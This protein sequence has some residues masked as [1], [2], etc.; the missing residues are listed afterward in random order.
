MLDKIFK[1]FLVIGSGTIISML[2]GLFTTPLITR[3]VSPY[4]YGQFSIFLMYGQIGILILILGLDQSIVRFFYESEGVKYKQWLLKEC[5][6]WPLFIALITSVVF[7]GLMITDILKFEFNFLFAILL[8]LYIFLLI[9]F[10]FAQLIVRLEYNS[11]LFSLLNIIQKFV[12]III[13]VPAI[14]FCNLDY[15]LVLVLAT[16]TALIICTIIAIYKYKDIWNFFECSWENFNVSEEHL[17]RY[18]YPYI[19]SF[20]IIA[21]FNSSDKLILNYY[22]SYSEVGIY[23]S[24]LSL[25]SIINLIQSTFNTLWAPLAV[26]HFTDFPDDREFYIRANKII[27]VVMFTIGIFLILCKDIFVLLLGEK[28]REASYLLPC[29]IFNPIM[30]TISETTVMGLVF[31]QKSKAHILVALGAAATNIVLCFVLIPYLG[32]KGAAIANALAYIVFFSIRT[33]LSNKYFKV[34]YD[35]KAFYITTLVV[36]FYSL[37]NCFNFVNTIDY[38]FSIICL[39]AIYYF[40]NDVFLLIKESLR[41][42]FRKNQLKN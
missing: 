16:I 7:I 38:L 32:I 24:A 19:I 27:T 40:Y 6:K 17:L 28:Y 11:K 35:L 3:I 22:C 20:A 23:A 21:L 12:Y 42:I 5:L 34:E 8:C 30:Y 37:Y 18:A 1:H 41:K 39:S 4:E 29:L 9:I 26:K 36:L 14:Y 15:L 33:Y 13:A 2:L 10:R 31:M 25:V